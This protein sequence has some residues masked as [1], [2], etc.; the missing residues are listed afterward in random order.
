MNAEP[1]EDGNIE[2]VPHPREKVRKS[3]SALQLRES[4]Y[5]WEEIAEILGL[6]DAMTAEKEFYKGQVALLK[7]NP[8]LISHLRDLT[9]RRLERLLRA[10]W[11]K[12]L[13]T[14]NP[15]QMVAHQRALA[16]IDRHAKL[17]G[18]DA[19]TKVDVEITPTQREMA[20]FVSAVIKLRNDLPEE[21]NIFG[22]AEVVE[23]EELEEGA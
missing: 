21:G 6:P 3:L 8:D 20:D 10:V 9:S 5:Q 11:T 2:F 15:E 16:V 18:L 23:I 17:F 1:A 12:A 19:A 22:D 4:G 14:N 13:D 7:E